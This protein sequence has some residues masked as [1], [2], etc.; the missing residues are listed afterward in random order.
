MLNYFFFEYLV[1]I[2]ILFFYYYFYYCFFFKLLIS[3]LL[4]DHT[5]TYLAGFLYGG[6]VQGLGGVWIIVAHIVWT[7]TN[8]SRWPPPSL[9]SSCSRGQ[10][11][12]NAW[13]WLVLIVF[14]HRGLVAFY[15]RIFD[16][17]YH[18]R[19]LYFYIK[20]GLRK[21]IERMALIPVMNRSNID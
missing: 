13:R 12:E 18:R 5:G 2:S 9:P 20:T 19:E 1:L 4:L 7:R 10:S 17:W 8:D 11:Q 16:F 3:G 15:R 21:S 14:N 6:I